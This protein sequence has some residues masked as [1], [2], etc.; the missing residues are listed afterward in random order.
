MVGFFCWH[1]LCALC[2]SS[3]T[4]CQANCRA[5]FYV[6]VLRDLSDA[7]GLRG[8]GHR[9]H[10]SAVRFGTA[11][12]P[13]ERSTRCASRL[14]SGVPQFTAMSNFHHYRKYQIYIS[15]VPE[16]DA[17]WRPLGIVLDPTKQAVRELKRIIGDETFDAEEQ[18]KFRA[19][20]M[21]REWIE[22]TGIFEE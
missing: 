13:S 6:M 3:V 14:R 7:W 10:L 21:C 15:T 9:K 19:L 8:W 20:E 12:L 16:I 17:T 4:R 18:A 1:K 22:L 5:K 2:E 11:C